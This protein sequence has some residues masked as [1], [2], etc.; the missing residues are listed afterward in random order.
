MNTLVGTPRSV[1]GFVHQRARNIFSQ[2]QL[3]TLLAQLARNVSKA[4]DGV[5]RVALGYCSCN[6][7]T[8]NL[9]SSACWWAMFGPPVFWLSFAQMESSCLQEAC[10]LQLLA[11]IPN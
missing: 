5:R 8:H 7:H 10:G 3:D 4:E 6:T 2:E 11:F 9:E 1:S